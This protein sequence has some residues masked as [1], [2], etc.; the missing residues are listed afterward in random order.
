MNTSLTNV[1]KRKKNAAKQRKYQE[2]HLTSGYQMRL[3]C[4][5]HT[6]AKRNL[7]R[8]ALYHG[9]T[10]KDMLETLIRAETNRV[11]STLSAKEETQFYDNELKRTAESVT[12]DRGLSA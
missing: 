9:C 12:H 10:I 1:E 4:L 2:R 11:V 5:I 8:L 3:S 7:E 6:S